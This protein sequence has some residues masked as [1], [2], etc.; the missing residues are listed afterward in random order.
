MKYILILV[1]LSACGQLP[2]RSTDKDFIPYVERF[3]VATGI[4]PDIS[5]S[6]NALSGYVGVCKIYNNGQR[7]IEIDREYWDNSGDLVKEEL[8]FHELGHCILNRKHDETM[9]THSDYRHR[10]PN[11]IMYPYIIGYTPFYEQFKLH[12]WEELTNP[13]KQL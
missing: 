2:Q 12:Y 6:F 10:F 4:I 8:L 3:V 7:R 11:S 1:I 13:G 9:T 5:I